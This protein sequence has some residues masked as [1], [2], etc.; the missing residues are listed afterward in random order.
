[1]GADIVVQRLFARQ[2]DI[3]KLGQKAGN[4]VN[5]FDNRVVTILI[6]F[7]RYM[8]DEFN[9]KTKYRWKFK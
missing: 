1:L 6:L 5:N 8:L 9:S 2:K 7:T 3:N 4:N